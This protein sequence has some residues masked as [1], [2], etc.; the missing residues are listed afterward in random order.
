ML[1]NKKG[2]AMLIVI[3][4]IFM[5]LTLSG[6]ALMLSSGHFRT[7]LKQ[8]EHTRAFFAVEAGLQHGLWMCRT[9][10]LPPGCSLTTGC[11]GASPWPIEDTITITDPSYSI[12]VDIKIYSPGSDPGTGIPAPAGTHPVVAIVDY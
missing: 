4:L 7:S 2:I 8:V 11:G 1:K 5:L 3:S 10:N 6:A 9:G 12:D